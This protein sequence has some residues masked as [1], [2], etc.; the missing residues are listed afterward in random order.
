MFELTNVKIFSDRVI[1]AILDHPK[2]FIRSDIP[3]STSRS[4]ETALK[5]RG[6]SMVSERWGDTLA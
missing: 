5:N 4:L 1:K 6:N 3:I 2:Y